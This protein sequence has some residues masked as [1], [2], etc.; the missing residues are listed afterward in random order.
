MT[1]E[2]KLI[3]GINTMQQVLDLIITLHYIVITLLTIIHK[4]QIRFPGIT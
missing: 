2:N 1:R 4:P 3:Q